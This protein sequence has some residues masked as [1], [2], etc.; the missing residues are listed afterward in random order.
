MSDKLLKLEKECLE[1][2]GVPEQDAFE[3]KQN[4]VGFFE[5]L[6]RIDQRLKREAQEKERK[7][8]MDDD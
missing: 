5:V 4:L 7:G 6:Y 3:A 1:A 2:L 8:G